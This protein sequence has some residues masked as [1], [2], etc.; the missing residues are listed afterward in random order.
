M[1]LLV[2]L[3]FLMLVDLLVLTGRAAD[4]RHDTDRCDWVA[5]LGSDRDPT[6]R[7]QRSLVAR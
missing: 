7:P 1:G 3:G 2:L 5:L 4:S 6:R